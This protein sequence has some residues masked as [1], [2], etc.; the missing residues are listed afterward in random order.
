M[1][2]NEI[3]L[4][5]RQSI[6]SG[7][8]KCEYMIVPII[9]FILSLGVLMMLINVLEYEGVFD[10]I[11]VLIGLALIGTFASAETIIIVMILLITCCL[12]SSNIIL[13]IIVFLFLA[14][15]YILY[16]HLFP[17]ESL[18]IIATFIAFA[19]KVEFA[20]PLLAALVGSYASVGAIIIGTIIWYTFPVLMRE[21]PT[22]TLDKSMILDTVNKLINMNYKEML[23]NKEM[24]IMCIILFIVFTSVYVIRKLGV[25]YGPYIAIGVG[26]VMN[27]LGVVLAKVFFTE[28]QV[29]ILGVI[30]MTILFTFVGMI[31]QFFLIALDYQRAEIVEFEDD[32][33]FYH[34]KI[35]PK[36]QLSAKQ[37]TVKHIYTDREQTHGSANLSQRDST[38]TQRQR[39]DRMLME[40]DDLRF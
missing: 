40:D 34:V 4:S 9:R 1:K 14:L 28:L 12:F 25:D 29:D 31:V 27:V 10:N 8:K 5:I 11:L 23:T 15:I 17:K 36:I 2:S 18:L 37:K 20:V 21:L 38:L 24:L 6:V 30:L 3:I 26:A 16:G 35:V 19:Y 7:F 39:M 22:M 13:A 33:N 32:D